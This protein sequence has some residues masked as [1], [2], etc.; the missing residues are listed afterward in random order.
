MAIECSIYEGDKGLP[1]SQ[2]EL[3]VAIAEFLESK[4]VSVLNERQLNTLAKSETA[5]CKELADANRECVPNSGLLPW[6]RSDSTGL[7]SRYMA[8][9]LS[10][11][12]G[13][14]MHCGKTCEADGT[15]CVPCDPSDFG[16]CIGLLDSCPPL[17]Q[18]L[19]K[20]AEGHGPIW[21]ELAERWDELE[22]LYREDFPTGESARLYRI[23]QA[24]RDKA[25]G[26]T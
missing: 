7:S 18:H 10:A 16:R 23:I 8:S 24:I 14:R 25:H 3:C 12:N 21:K 17:R 6:L 9:V 2:I 22:A 15:P 26:K 1:F 4:G 19:P 13:T 20:L 11:A 5:I